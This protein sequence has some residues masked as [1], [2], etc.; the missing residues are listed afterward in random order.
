[1]YVIH[2]GSGQQKIDW[3]GDTVCHRHD[4]H[5]LWDVGT[6]QDIRLQNGVMVNLKGI[7]CEEL[8]DDVHVYVQL[9]GKSSQVTRVYSLTLLSASIED[10]LAQE[11]AD[12]NAGKRNRRR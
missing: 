7:I 11:I 9:L 3:L 10:T 4:P 5:N 1:M 2:C 8:Q 6:L 12:P